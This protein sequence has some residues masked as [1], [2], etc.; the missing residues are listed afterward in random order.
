MAYGVNAPF[1]LRPLSSISGGSWTE[2]VNEYYIYASANGQAT[3]GT[4]IFTGDP[5]IWNTAAGTTIS[6]IPTI[7][8][9][10]IDNATVVNEI[11]PVLGVFAGCEYFSTVNGTNNLI[12]S[13]YWPASTQVVGG[14]LIKAF[15]ID[16]PDVVW[17]IQV[18]TATNVANDARFGG[19]TNQAATLAYM[20]QNFAFGLAGGG[21]ELGP[22]NNPA[23]G[24]NTTG[25]SAIYLNMVGTA[26]TNRVAATL[27]LKALGYTQNP[28]NY[29]YEDDGTTARQFLNVRVVI[30]NHVYRVGNLGTTL[31]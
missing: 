8:R 12:K 7:A 11:S 21:A 19:T 13:P 28:N 30:N 18:S 5:V 2:K 10:P 17:D 24:S 9:Y 1:G 16:D 27:P 31:A 14:T 3:Y 20:G 6:A 15:V 29:I 23:V 25:Q 26:A 22:N 4:S